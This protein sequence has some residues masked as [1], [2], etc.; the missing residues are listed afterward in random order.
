[1]A[2]T[3][4]VSSVVRSWKL[5][6]VRPPPETQAANPWTIVSPATVRMSSASSPN[7][8]GT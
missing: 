3:L 7:S 5:A 8:C 4:G 1:M 2:P 6:T